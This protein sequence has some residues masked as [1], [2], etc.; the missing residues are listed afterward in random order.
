MFVIQGSV[1]SSTTSY[2]GYWSDYNASA[3]I[4]TVTF[5]VAVPDTVKNKAVT[6]L[7]LI[8]SNDFDVNTAKRV[9]MTKTDETFTPDAI[10]TDVISS[11]AD[12]S[13]YTVTVDADQ[14]NEM[15]SCY[16]VGFIADG[17]VLK[18]DFSWSGNILRA[19]IG[20]YESPYDT[21]TTA[22]LYDLEGATFVVCGASNNNT[23]I[24]RGYWELA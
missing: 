9:A 10:Y 16:R 12:W 13:V 6:S 19:G 11:T 4:R 17:Q 1:S 8:Y 21:T 7:D 24:M 18:T 2:L 22:S 20:A 14:I 15:Q 5:K 23:L 3:S